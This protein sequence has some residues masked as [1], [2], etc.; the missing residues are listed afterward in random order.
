MKS[1]KCPYCGHEIDENETICPNCKMELNT[2]C[3]FC[4]QEIKAYEDVCPY[5]TSKLTSKKEPKFLLPL[6][7][8]LSALWLILNIIELYLICKYPMMLKAKDKHGE[9]VFGNYEYT[10]I[11]LKCFVVTAVP[12]IIAIVKNYKKEIAIICIIINSI[13]AICFTSFFIYYRH[14]YLN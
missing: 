12:Y 9:Y 14:A 4:K 10:N 6:G 1:I 13:I 5:C 8:T 7:Y 2:I 3:P 11:L